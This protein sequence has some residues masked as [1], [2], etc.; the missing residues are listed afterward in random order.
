MFR[1]LTSVLAVTAL[2][3]S[4]CVSPLPP[5]DVASLV[6]WIGR[7]ESVA[8]DISLL[9]TNEQTRQWGE[10]ASGLLKELK[11]GLQSGELQTVPG[12]I[13]KLRE[14]KPLLVDGLKA[15]GVDENKIL[16]VLILLES[17]LTGLE[18]TIVVPPVPPPVP[19]VEP[20][21]PR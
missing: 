4:G 18:E 5:G 2:F 1:F 9:A 14:K 13:N 16:L 21:A 3:V 8:T 17:A 20:P 6:K 10:E 7:L 19:P 12:L 15:G 11:L